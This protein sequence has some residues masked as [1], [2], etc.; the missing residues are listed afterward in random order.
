MLLPYTD[1]YARVTPINKSLFT[2]LHRGGGVASMLFLPNSILLLAFTPH[3]SQD[4][5]CGHVPL[6]R[7]YLGGGSYA[8]ASAGPMTYR[9]TAIALGPRISQQLPIL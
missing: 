9:L 6:G 7:R 3:A 2:I 5:L 8:H 1:V 4:V